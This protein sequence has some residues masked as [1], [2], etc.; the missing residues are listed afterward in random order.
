MQFIEGLKDT[1]KVQVNIHN[2]S[3]FDDAVAVA[4][5]IDDA[6]Y[7]GLSSRNGATNTFYG[8]NA[9]ASSS[10]RGPQAMELGAVEEYGE[11]DAHE[12]GEPWSVEYL[13]AC[14]SVTAGSAATFRV[15]EV[16]T[17]AGTRESLCCCGRTTIA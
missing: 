10:Y 16:M 17:G 11:E 9:G 8:R 6:S 14:N 3:S 2:P 4:E 12:V 7:S 13:A 1:V 5:R 15:T